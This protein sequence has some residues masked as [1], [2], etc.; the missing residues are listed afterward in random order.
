MENFSPE[1]GNISM[2]MH[3]LLMTQSRRLIALIFSGA[4][5]EGLWT[6]NRKSGEGKYTLKESGTFHCYFEHDKMRTEGPLSVKFGKFLN[7]H[8]SERATSS[9]RP[10]KEQ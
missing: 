3:V 4:I 8:R 5:F 9:E 6:E 1:Y 10:C 7:K 2:C